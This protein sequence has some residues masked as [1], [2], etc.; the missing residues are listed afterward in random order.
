MQNTEAARLICKELGVTDEQFYQAIQNFEGADKR[1]EAV[2]ESDKTVIF[3]DFAHAPSKVAAS[4]NAV[5][6]KYPDKKLIAVLELHTYSSL[7]QKFLPEYK[8]KLKSADE[9]I[10]FYSPRAVAIKRLE[11][12][13]PELIVKEF[14]RPDLK[15][16]TEPEK[17]HEY[18]YHKNLKDAVLLL[19]SSGNYG[20]LETE[21]LYL[22]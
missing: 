7:N 5:R 18:L 14:N 6:E 19:M 1:L 8:D 2:F 20:G 13:P 16:F 17:L 11:P 10:V 22:R 12:I 15:V 4:L 21:K 9:A 3:K